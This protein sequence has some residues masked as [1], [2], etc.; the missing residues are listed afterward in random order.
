MYFSKSQLVQQF[1][2]FDKDG[3]GYISLTEASEILS[4][5]PFNFPPSKQ[6]VLLRQFDKDGNGKLD[7][8]EFSAFYAEIKAT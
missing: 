2:Q 7:I 3:N 5:D 6:L 8:E 4:K 1:K